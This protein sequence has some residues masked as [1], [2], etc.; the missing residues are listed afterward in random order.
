M[1]K[2]N[3]LMLVGLLLLPRIVAPAGITVDGTDST[4]AVD[5]VCSLREAINNAND[6]MVL[7]D[8]CLI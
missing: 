2:Y 7:S 8:R 5:G 4:I 1:R 3:I 6:T